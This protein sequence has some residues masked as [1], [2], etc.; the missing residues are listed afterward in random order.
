MANKV[1]GTPE[2]LNILKGDCSKTKKVQKKS[3]IKSEFTRGNTLSRAGKR[4]RFGF[5]PVVEI[6]PWRRL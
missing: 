4:C 3:V 2:E 1:H 6:T 5:V